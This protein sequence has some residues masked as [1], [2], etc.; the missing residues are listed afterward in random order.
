MSR[1]G[2]AL[3]QVRS[4]TCPCGCTL[5][6]RDRSDVGPLQW[7]FLQCTLEPG[8]VV[9]RSWCAAIERTLADATTY[10]AVFETVLACWT[11]RTEGTIHTA[12]AD[13]GSDWPPMASAPTQGQARPAPLPPSGGDEPE[14]GFALP[15]STARSSMA[16]QFFWCWRVLAKAAR[17]RGRVCDYLLSF[18]YGRP[19]RKF[20]FLPTPWTKH[21]IRRSS[22]CAVET[23]RVFRL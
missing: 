22:P 1:C 5:E 4:P 13:Q 9:R 18:I 16:G 19:W 14:P 11:H 10:L 20:P 7:Q 21:L 2:V 17:R 3:Q 8:R 12:A 6:W 23:N 15:P